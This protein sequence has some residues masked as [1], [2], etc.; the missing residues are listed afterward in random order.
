MKG[1]RKHLDIE[2]ELQKVD[3]SWKEPFGYIHTSTD[4]GEWAKMC[5]VEEVEKQVN[6]IIDNRLRAFGINPK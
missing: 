2:K 1:I 5:T 3:I 4:D 6:I